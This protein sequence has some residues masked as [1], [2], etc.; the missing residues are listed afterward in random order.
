MLELIQYWLKWWKQIAVFCAIAI[1]LSVII[2]M[3]VFMKP[4][5]SSRMVFYPANPANSDRSVLFSDGNVLT[6]NFG[7]KDD[8]NR[9]L[10]IANSK[11]LVKYMVDSFKLR[12]HYNDIEDPGYYYVGREFSSNYK[13]IRN[14]LGAIE[15]EILDTDPELAAKMVRTAVQYVD[16]SYRNMLSANKRTTHGIM[17]SE[18]HRKSKELSIM[19]D[20]LSKLKKSSSYF[21]DKDGN[22]IGDERLRMLDAAFQNLSMDVNSLFTITSQYEV[23][24]AEKYPSIHIVEDAAVAEKKVKPV[25]WLIVLATGLGAFIAATL[26][27][28]I[29]ELVK[30]AKSGIQPMDA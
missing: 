8:I 28:I 26:A 27:I 4:Y 14:D 29:I 7:S 10:A 19:A 12:E 2:S 6:D 11:E 5:Y 25:R 9:F 15:M 18:L 30:H 24:L 17:N 3:P 21:Y 20:S 22:L 13:A 16:H 1:V 23:S